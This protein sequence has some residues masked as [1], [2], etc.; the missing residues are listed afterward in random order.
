M[1]NISG[2]PIFKLIGRIVIGILVVLILATLAITFVLTD[3]KASPNIFG[4]NLYLMR[5]TNMEPAIPDKALVIS[6][7]GP[8]DKDPIG[9]VALCNIVDKD[10]TTVVRVVGV[11]ATDGVATYL[12]QSDN[13]KATSVV[14]IPSDK[15]IGQATHV[16]PIV[17]IILTFATSQAGIIVLIILPCIAILVYQL[18]RILRKV[19]DSKQDDEIEKPTVSF[20][21]DNDDSDEAIEFEDFEPEHFVQPDSD[22]YSA[23]PKATVDKNGKAEYVKVTPTAGADALDKVLQP[24]SG[25]LMNEQQKKSFEFKADDE[26]D[27]FHSPVKPILTQTKPALT[28]QNDVFIAPRKKKPSSNATLE[29]LMKML[30]KEDNKPE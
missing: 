10:L 22:Q 12:V 2:N 19:D 20:D 26:S 28:E 3:K 29:K 13:A 1:N 14:S 24:A 8:L 16:V 30:D 23:S 4:Y 11:D 27:S 9:T 25:T 18:I 5:G 17:G 15:V 6:K 7:V 21:F